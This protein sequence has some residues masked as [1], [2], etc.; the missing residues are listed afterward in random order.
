M[1]T[2]IALPVRLE[3]GHPNKLA[4]LPPRMTNAPKRHRRRGPGM[5]AGA[6]AS[7]ALAALLLALFAAPAGAKLRPVGAKGLAI[8]GKARCAERQA[9]RVVTPKRVRVKIGGKRFRA[10]VLAPKRVGARKRARVRVKFGGAAVRRLDGRVAKVRL[11]VVLRSRGER[12]V[13]RLETRVQRATRG[14]R[15]GAGGGGGAGAA[16]PPTSGALSNEPPPLARPLTA[17]DVGAVQLSWYPRDS[18]VR[19]ASSGTGPGDGILFAAGAG[20]LLSSASPCP[21]RPNS[22]DAQ[23]YYTAQFTPRASW[24]DPVS[25]VAGVYGQG[26]VSFRWTGHGIDLTAADPEI[27]INGAASRAIFRFNRSGGTAYPNQ[28]A[29][30]LS[31]DTAGGPTITNGGKTLTYNLM[32]GTLTANGVNVFAGFYTPPSNDEFG[33]VSVS[34]TT[35]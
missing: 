20:G 24:Y 22:S 19:Y 28:R 17:V 2:G 7:A 32:R 4:I 34:F 31:L 23:L 21:D 35:P 9:C 3:L 11:R 25:G 29:D 18:W 10:R 1:E 30:L 12:R 15:G 5:A 16:T 6:L 27:E 33:C 13:V 14:G 8:V 26:S